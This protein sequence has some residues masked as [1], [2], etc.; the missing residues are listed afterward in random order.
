MKNSEAQFTV[1]SMQ[2]PASAKPALWTAILLHAAKNIEYG[3]LSITLPDGSRR[4]FRGQ[5]ADRPA[6]ALVLYRPRAARQ[7]ILG[8]DVG[9]AESYMSGDWDS[10]DLSA[11]LEL[12]AINER[13]MGRAVTGRLPIR[14]WHAITH[15]LR[16]N[17]LRGSR[18]NIAAHYDLGN[19]FYRQW[20]DPSMT[21]SSALFSHDR[22]SL[23]EAQK[24]KYRRICEKLELHA[25]HHI[26]EIGCGWGGFAELAA[27]EYGCRVTGIT[28]SKEQLAYAR[29]RIANAGLSDR[30]DFQM[31]DYRHTSGKYDAIVSIEMF[32]AVGEEYWPCFFRTVRERLKPNGLA[33]FQIITIEDR[34]FAAYR[35][36]EDFIQR[37]IFPGGLLP[38]PSALRH[39]LES[40]SFTVTDWMDFG[41]SYARTLAEW[42][43]RFQETW[44]STESLGFD[45]RFKRM[46]E[47]YLAY[48]EGGF[49]AGAI[50]VTQMVLRPA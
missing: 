22:Q 15:R 17:S 4:V 8:G 49:R 47:F 18:Q 30:V 5:K 36:G 23:I 28:L 43:R 21:Y 31:Q 39:C 26:L 11:L 25:G 19:D 37:Y 46:W 41:D 44:N 32:E 29:N 16:R 35:R 33:V 9:F 12:A 38:S 6:A 27:R 50:D 13:N 45:Q 42:N 1:S 20:L 2:T 7:L 10:P 24:A 48:C 3:L 34:R 14:L 40:Q